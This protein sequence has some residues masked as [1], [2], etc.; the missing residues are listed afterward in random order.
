[1]LERIVRVYDEIQIVLVNKN[2]K[3]HSDKNI[4][5]DQLGVIK[6]FLYV[7][8]PVYAVTCKLC[9]EKLSTLSSILPSIY[10]IN[11]EF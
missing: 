10:Y 5:P 11:F 4:K 9:S 8:K 6:L 2:F 3:K 7:L 1:M